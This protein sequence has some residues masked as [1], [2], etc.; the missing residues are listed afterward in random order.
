MP[1]RKIET[2]TGTILVCSRGRGN[3]SCSV[4]GCR[5]RARYLCDY[6]VEI[7]LGDGQVG[8]TTCDKP[9]CGEHARRRPCGKDWCYEHPLPTAAAKA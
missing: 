8:K 5:N 9:L 6:P 2:P 4:T 3:R 1:C 7:D